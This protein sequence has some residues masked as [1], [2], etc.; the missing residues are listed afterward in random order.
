MY[1]LKE[2]EEFSWD[3]WTCFLSQQQMMFYMFSCKKVRRFLHFIFWS[4][5][6]R[7][8][9]LVSCIVQWR[10]KA[11]GSSCLIWGQ[12]KWFLCIK[13]INWSGCCNPVRLI[14]DVE[15]FKYTE[16]IY[17]ERHQ[18]FMIAIPHFAL[19]WTKQLCDLRWTWWGSML[20]FLVVEL[21]TALALTPSTAAM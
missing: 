19:T 11:R 21:S 18:F 7:S 20:F 5:R 17:K 2:H 10:Q 13:F 9:I 15:K 4:F 8:I 14:I 16:W 6:S 1:F 12:Q 3:F